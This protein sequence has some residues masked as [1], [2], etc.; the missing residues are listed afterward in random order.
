MYGLLH[1]RPDGEVALTRD[2]RRG[3]EGSKAGSQPVPLPFD[4]RLLVFR[5]GNGVEETTGRLL[6][7]KLDYLQVR[8]LQRIL[9]VAMM[10]NRYMYVFLNNDI[11]FA[12][13]FKKRSRQLA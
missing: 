5:R 11:G 10:I 3:N 2:G 4:G 7:K 1:R 13:I 8:W 6:L 12:T 9:E